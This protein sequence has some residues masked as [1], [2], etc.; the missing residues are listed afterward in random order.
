MIDEWWN[1]RTAWMTETGRSTSRAGR[2]S[3]SYSVDTRTF[4]ERSCEDTG[5]TKQS[6][7]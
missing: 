3:V 4:G 2:V 7:Q 6:F 1:V 5:T